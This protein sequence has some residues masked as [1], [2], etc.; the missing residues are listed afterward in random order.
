MEQQK[1]LSFKEKYT[2]EQRKTESKTKRETNPKLYPV[3]VEKH[4]RSKLPDLEKAK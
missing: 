4:H 3:V 2:L 1:V